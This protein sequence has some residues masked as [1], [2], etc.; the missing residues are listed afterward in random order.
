MHFAQNTVNENNNI[1][2]ISH[3][4]NFSISC[5]IMV[6]NILSILS[7]SV[8]LLKEKLSQIWNE[9]FNSGKLSNLYFPFLRY[10][11]DEV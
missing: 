3:T 2:I 5:I 11:K 8:F 1:C 10:G 4:F 6:I 9:E 7:H